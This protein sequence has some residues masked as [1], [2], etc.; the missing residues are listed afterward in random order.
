M[1]RKIC[2][3]GKSKALGTWHY[4]TYLQHPPIATCASKDQISSVGCKHYILETRADKIVRQIE[5]D[6]YTVGE[7]AGFRDL[8]SRDVFEYDVVEIPMLSRTCQN[9]GAIKF[10]DVTTA[11]V[12]FEL[13]EF[14]GLVIKQ[15]T[16]EYYDLGALC[17]FPYYPLER[18]KR[19]LRVVGNLDDNPEYAQMLTNL[20]ESIVGLYITNAKENQEEANNYA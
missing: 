3:R 18:G 9:G 2:F 1:N 10:G 8:T 17:C 13:G 7:Y 6:S 19:I 5:I 4:G 12:V 15:N 11:V 16:L 14:M 20:D